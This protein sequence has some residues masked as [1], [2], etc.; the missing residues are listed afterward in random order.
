M[1]APPKIIDRAQALA[2]GMLKYFTG[3]PCAAGHTAERYVSGWSCC[4]CVNISRR[5]REAAFKGRQKK[6][7]PEQLERIRKNGAKPERKAKVAA[8]CREYNKRPEVKERNRLR[9]HARQITPE[10][11]EKKAAYRK[12]DAG[13][14]LA[15][16][17]RAS[18]RAAQAAAT[19]AWS[20]SRKIQEI[21]AACPA[22]HHVDHFV[23]IKGLTY[24]GR[25]VCGLHVHENLRY[26]SAKENS[27][28]R[29]RMTR[30]ET[31]ATE[32][33]STYAINSDAG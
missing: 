26:L 2:L 18:R 8:Y 13:R 33:V 22:G 10:R 5:A 14:A 19:P 7:S 24:D 31:E 25:P 9:A 11:A 29:N 16:C 30:E 21:Y 28:R 17:Y 12:S 1:E 3:R 32:C 4:E 27:S 6:P 15:R 23:P 20:D